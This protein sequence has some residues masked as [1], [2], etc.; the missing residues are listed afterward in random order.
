MRTNIVLDDELVT[1]AM[2]I[3]KARSKREVVDLALRGLLQKHHSRK[4][5]ELRGQPLFDPAYDVRK[6]RRAM[7]RDAG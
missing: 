1:E 3:T 5:K 4:F 7:D 2:K 6:V